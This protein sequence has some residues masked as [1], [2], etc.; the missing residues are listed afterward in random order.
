MRKG[1][2]GRGGQN[3]MNDK[4]DTQRKKKR[5]RSSIRRGAKKRK[6]AC[7]HPLGYVSSPLHGRVC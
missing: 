6:K 1:L 4:R 3:E 5:D 7:E 2:E